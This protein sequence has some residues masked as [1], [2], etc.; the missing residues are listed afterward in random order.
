MNTYSSLLSAYRSL[1]GPLSVLSFHL[2]APHTVPQLHFIVSGT[3]E[4]Q[5]TEVLFLCLRTHKR[6]S[7]EKNQKNLAPTPASRNT[8]TQQTFQGRDGSAC[9]HFQNGSSTPLFNYHFHYQGTHITRDFLVRKIGPELTSV[10]I[11]HYF[12]C[13]MP[14]QL[15]R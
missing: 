9:S 5:K 4:T 3:K 11:F 12:A 15:G 14:P 6:L 2:T 10:P 7:L 8:S 13:K 1:Q